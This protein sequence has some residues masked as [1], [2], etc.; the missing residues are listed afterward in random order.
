MEQ[1][2]KSSG[3]ALFESLRQQFQTVGPGKAT[4]VL[5]LSAAALC[6]IGVVVGIVCGS[7]AIAK[8]QASPATESYKP[9]A[10]AVTMP[11]SCA[12]EFTKAPP[13]LPELTAASV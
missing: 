10:M 6:L 4:R 2:E 3:K 11:I 13:L 12:C 7:V 5:L 8:C 1:Q 9:E